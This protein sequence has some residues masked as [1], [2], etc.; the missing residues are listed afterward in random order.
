[1]FAPERVESNFCLHFPVINNCIHS[2]THTT[3]SGQCRCERTARSLYRIAVLY[4]QFNLSVVVIT[5]MLP[6]GRRLILSVRRCITQQN[7][8]NY[9]IKRR[10]AW[11]YCSGT[12]YAQQNRF[13]HIINTLVRIHTT[14]PVVSRQNLNCDIYCNYNTQR[15]WT[16]TILCVPQ[17]RCLHIN[18][19]THV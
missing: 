1:M 3:S 16:P 5:T 18:A 14:T 7:H 4:V 12:S 11:N 17:E 13:N 6:T 10:V 19:V 15:G 2:H 9:L 8:W